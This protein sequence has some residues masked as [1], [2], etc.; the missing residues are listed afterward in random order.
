MTVVLGSEVSLNLMPQPWEKAVQ[1]ALEGDVGALKLLL[2]RVIP[3]ARPKDDPIVLEDIKP[4]MSLSDRAAR[5][6]ALI[7]SG[8]ISPG[9]GAV[10]LRALGSEA[11]IL[12]V[13][14]LQ[15]RITLLEARLS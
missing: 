15:T 4:D 12:E 1:I 3:Q 13:S 5:V 6:S 2:S 14:E 8:E 10:V 9:D 7:A 11:R